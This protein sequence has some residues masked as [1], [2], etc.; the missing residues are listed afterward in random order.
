MHVPVERMTSSR[1]FHLESAYHAVDNVR[2]EYKRVNERI[3][4]H[5]RRVTQARLPDNA[6]VGP[7]L[8]YGEPD[9]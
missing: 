1:R 3:A 8:C 9:Y 7:S 6:L 2:G 5:R 4:L